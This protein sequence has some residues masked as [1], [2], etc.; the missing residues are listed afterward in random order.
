[1]RREPKRCFFG[2]HSTI[3]VAGRGVR[4]SQHVE[5]RRV[6]MSC[7]IDH[8]LAEANRLIRIAQGIVG[9]GREEPREIRERCRKIGPE[10][11]RT[12]DIRDRQPDEALK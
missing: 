7:Q 4:G 5:C 10:L 11:D 6:M 9:R 12:P 8:V 3:E 2:L 1:M